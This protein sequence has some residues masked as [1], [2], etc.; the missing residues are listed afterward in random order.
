MAGYQK[1][2]L[3]LSQSLEDVA[4]TELSNHLPH[5]RQNR[6]ME[7]RALKGLQVLAKSGIQ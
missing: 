5:V 1:G 4:D 3:G 6:R 2:P 7:G